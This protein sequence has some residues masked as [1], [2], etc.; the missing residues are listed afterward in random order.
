MKNIKINL[1]VVLL[2]AVSLYAEDRTRVFNLSGYWR[3]SI[4]D[5]AEWKNT[6]FND[7][8]W[9]DIRVPA[10]WEDKGYHGYDGYAWYRKQFIISDK[11]LNTQLYVELGYVDD[12]DE[13]YINGVLIGKSGSFPPAYITSYFSYR[14]YPIPMG[15]LKPGNNVIAVRVFDDEQGGGIVNGEPGIYNY[16]SISF[17]VGLEGYWKFKPAN[18]EEFKNINFDDSKWD[19]II[20]PGFWENQGYKDYDGYAWYRKKFKVSKSIAGQKLVLVMGKIDDYDQVYINGKLVGS[21]GQ[22]SNVDNNLG[23]SYDK[24]RG[25]YLPDNILNANG[26]NVIAVRVYDGYKDGGIYEGPIGITTQKS[27]VEFWKK[28]EKRS[29]WDRIFNN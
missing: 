11:Y 25:Y 19:E 10:F 3:F 28:K 12:V 8:N 29:F 22:I 16:K 6:G 24:F 2:L 14:K 9:E 15:L 5:N 27:Y 17:A 13:T 7:S 1:V 23:D 18:N 4:G 21:T 20:V 26:D